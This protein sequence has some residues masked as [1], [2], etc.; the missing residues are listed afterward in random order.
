[1]FDHMTQLRS[2]WNLGFS[3]IR[4]NP[5]PLRLISGPYIRPS[6]GRFS[7]S[8]LCPSPYAVLEED[9]T[10]ADEPRAEN[11]GSGVGVMLEETKVMIVMCG[12][13]LRIN[14][15][16]KREWEGWLEA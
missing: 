5:P 11:V 15:R 3:A 12:L 4:T 16:S 14:G 1:M 10:T 9:T 13:R 8:N 7:S 2:N 6:I